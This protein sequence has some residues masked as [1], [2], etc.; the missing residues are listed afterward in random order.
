[1]EDIRLAQLEKEAALANTAADKA[2]ESRISALEDGV[3]SLRES[4]GE[5]HVRLPQA[6][7]APIQELLM[8][9]HQLHLLKASL[10]EKDARIASLES[11]VTAHKELQVCLARILC[12]RM[13]IFE[14]VGVPCK[15]GRWQC[16]WLG[17]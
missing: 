8:T 12:V 11:E 13:Q 3:D 1:M 14:L 9:Q 2:M 15:A 6:L 7:A 5:A 4:V 16:I 10:G 17:V